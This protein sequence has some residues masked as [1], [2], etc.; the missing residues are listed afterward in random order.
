MSKLVSITVEC[1]ICKIINDID[2]IKPSRLN[3]TIK[4]AKCNE[5]KLSM[6]LRVRPGREQGEVTIDYIRVIEAPKTTAP[7][8]A[9]TKGNEN[10]NHTNA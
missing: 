10:G 4:R 9:P 1:P 2:V 7:E 8:T 6:L 5:C 3:P